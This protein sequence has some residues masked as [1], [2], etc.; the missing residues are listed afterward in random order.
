MAE[1]LHALATARYHNWDGGHNDTRCSTGWVNT[2]GAVNARECCWYEDSS[3]RCD[4]LAI[5]CGDCLGED[6]RTERLSAGFRAIRGNRR[7]THRGLGVS[8]CNGDDDG[9]WGSVDSGDSCPDCGNG[10]DC[11]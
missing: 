1:R 10:G 3:S 7:G 8:A 11:H 5:G 9:G 2:R 4:E 6:A